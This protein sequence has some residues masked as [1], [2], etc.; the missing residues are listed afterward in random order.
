MIGQLLWR[1]DG[2]A[3]WSAWDVM[4][5]V[6]KLDAP[7][8]RASVALRL[9]VVSEACAR[10]W[11]ARE[12]G[13]EP[14]ARVLADAALVTARAIVP[15]LDQELRIYRR[16]APML[17]TA[18][19][20]E[21]LAPASFQAPELRAIAR[22]EQL[23]GPLL[24]RRTRLRFHVAAL[25]RGL[26]VLVRRLSL[27]R[28]LAEHERLAVLNGLERDLAIL[29][30]ATLAC[31]RAFRSSLFASRRRVERETRSWPLVEARRNAPAPTPPHVM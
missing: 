28:D 23:V 22:V 1:R 18:S 25:R 17:Q 2:E 8:P 6:R 9:S 21:P 13:D 4:C 3:V 31:A 29:A 16:N 26:S 20:V 10:A 12:S 5:G 24:G 7:N 11:A 14:S 19:K 30:A 15:Q 27:T